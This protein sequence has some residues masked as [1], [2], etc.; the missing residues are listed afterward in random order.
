MDIKHYLSDAE[1]L[2]SKKYKFGVKKC[3]KTMLLYINKLGIILLQNIKDPSK[4]RNVSGHWRA[5]I[6]HP[7]LK[8]AWNNAN[9]NMR[10][11]QRKFVFDNNKELGNGEVNWSSYAGRFREPTSINVLF[12]AEEPDYNQT[13]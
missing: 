2:G 10:R 9:I 6:F 11:Q 4:N 13:F 3:T 5:D 1:P 8:R 12:G 7:G